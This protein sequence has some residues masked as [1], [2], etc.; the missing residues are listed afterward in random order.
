MI[1]KK[2]GVNGSRP[3]PDAPPTQRPGVRVVEG[4]TVNQRSSAR[5][6]IDGSRSLPSS[7]VTHISVDK[8]QIDAAKDMSFDEIFDMRIDSKSNLCG[9]TPHEVVQ[10][11][12]TLLKEN[13]PQNSRE[14]FSSDGAP[15]P[16]SSEPS[17]RGGPARVRPMS[18]ISS[19]GAADFGGYVVGATPDSP[20]RV[21]S[22]VMPSNRQ[23]DAVGGRGAAGRMKSG[24]TGSRPPPIKPNLHKTAA[25]SG[26]SISGWRSAPKG[27]TEYIAMAHSMSISNDHVPCVDSVDTKV[28]SIGG[29]VATPR[30][31]N[32]SI[33]RSV[34]D[35]NK[36][37]TESKD[38]TFK[39]D[40]AEVIPQDYSNTTVISSVDVSAEHINVSTNEEWKEA[41]TEYASDEP[42]EA[43]NTDV[44]YAFNIPTAE[45]DTDGDVT[46][47]TATSTTNAGV[48]E[49]ETKTD[50]VS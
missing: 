36:P 50:V 45:R 30:G 34:S 33:I 25:A 23:G 24:A 26:T 32:S 2:F 19:S 7:R 29:G 49:D 1:F 15:A 40:V 8:T 42:T 17:H 18:T 48:S 16:G 41:L 20:H 14:H 10:Q 39:E 6:H 27:N 22:P 38:V 9:P 11:A 47:H 3:P 35:Y 28:C 13:A 31:H 46:S 43:Q 21:M 4:Y 5:K 37:R 12:E 44:K